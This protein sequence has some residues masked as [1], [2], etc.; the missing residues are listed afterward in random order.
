VRRPDGHK[1]TFGRVLVV[2]GSSG[3]VGAAMLCC[4]GAL[5]AGAGLV[6]L[7]VPEP[8]A[9]AVDVAL[10][11]VLTIPLPREAG[12]IPPRLEA[13]LDRCDALAIGPGLSRAPRIL[14]R[15]S[16]ILDR[17]AG[18]VV[19]DADALAV[20]ADAVR[21]KDLAGR[22]VLTPH[23]GEMAEILGRPLEEVAADPR[24]CA[25]AF[26]HEHGCVLLLK[27]APTIIGN[28]SGPPVVNPTG[29]HGLASGGSGDVLT[30]LI[31]GLLAGGAGSLDAA[32]AGAYLHGAAA[33]HFA[34]RGAARS[35]IPSDLVDRVP[36]VL[37]EIEG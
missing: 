20:I 13:L 8:L 15:A 25:Q 29:H 33:D 18:P 17:F 11:E 6:F 34:R 37:K 24:G 2:A 4:R 22:A 16:A 9:S 10:P 3:M 31:A 1:G 26:A 12:E 36:F 32:I 5:R 27:G 19:I 28:P 30:G 35:L 21:R 23:P 7:A 14:D